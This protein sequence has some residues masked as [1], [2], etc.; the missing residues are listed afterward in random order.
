MAVLTKY[1]RILLVL[2]V[3]RS[4]TVAVVAAGG[5]IEI[6]SQLRLAGFVCVLRMENV[7][8]NVVKLHA[9]RRVGES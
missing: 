4:G 5:T 2:R 7:E 1:G 3:S 9:K 6:L 8:L